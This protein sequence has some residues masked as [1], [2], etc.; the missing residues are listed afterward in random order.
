MREEDLSASTRALDSG[1][2]EGRRGLAE[3][4]RHRALH[5]ASLFGLRAHD[6]DPS[7]SSEAREPLA[8]S[9]SISRSINRSI[10]PSSTCSMP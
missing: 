8:W 10:S 5:D 3:R 4:L 7:D 2:G 6:S 9:D 1:S